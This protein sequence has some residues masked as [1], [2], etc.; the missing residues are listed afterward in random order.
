MNK[1]TALV[2]GSGFSG[3]SAAINLAHKGFEVKILEKNN[4]IGGRARQFS[5]SGFTF[6]MGPS[7]YWMPDVFESFFNKFGKSVTDYY[8]LVRLDPS[9]QVVYENGDAMP[10]PAQMA[11]LK[12]LFD[13]IEPGSGVQLD[14]F[15]K[16]AAYKYEVG[17]NQL[18]YKPGRTLTEFA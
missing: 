5:E 4:S 3:L 14:E 11:E 1:K 7:W 10:I 17:I 13:S 15:L 9:Y 12:K 16:Q 18:V 2:I 6:D 8:D